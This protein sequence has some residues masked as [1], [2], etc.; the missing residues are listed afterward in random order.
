MI[1]FGKIHMNSHMDAQCRHM[2][3]MIST[4]ENACLL[5]AKKDDGLTSSG[6]EKA[7]NEIMKANRLFKKR[8]EKLM[9]KDDG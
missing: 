4:F 7:L 3:T 8:L 6:E 5:A 2:I 1:S 9:I